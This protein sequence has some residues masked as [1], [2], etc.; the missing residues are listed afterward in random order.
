MATVR[1]RASVLTSAEQNL[2]R[3][4]I[5]QLIDSGFYG[6]LVA[7]HGDM[8]HDQHGGMG[9]IGTQRFL[10]WHRDFLLQLEREL[11]GLDPVASIPY[12]DWTAQRGVPPWKDDFLP[13]VPVPGRRNPIQ[14][15]RSIGRRGRLPAGWEVE[16][17]IRNSGVNY[18]TFTSV[19]EGF[20]NEVH[21]WVGGAMG[22]I[23]VSP[24]DPLFWMHHAQV[25]RLWSVWQSMPSN[26]R[27]APTL[28]G[29]D[30]ILDP[31]PE[32]ASEMQSI[33]RLDYSYAQ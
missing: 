15:R 18:T 13:T 3:N 11:Q 16:A 5:T 32:R 12:W 24:A 8:S 28:R 9:A 31:W 27:K 17:L 22:S 26:A 4:G 21:G 30:A 7:L 23:M 33:S 29:R 1:K 10:P 25:D 20:H 14:V 6:Q 2:Y 19:L